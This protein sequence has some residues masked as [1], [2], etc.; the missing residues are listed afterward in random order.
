MSKDVVASYNILAPEYYDQ[1]RHP[2]CANLGEL[3][4][5]FIAK[6]LNII[7]SSQRVLEIGAGSSNVAMLLQANHHSISQL[8][9]TDI[10]EQM[11]SH[12]LMWKRHGASVYTADALALPHS[13]SSIDCVIA[14]LID[15]YNTPKLWTSLERILTVDG[16]IIVTTPSYE[17]AKRFRAVQGEA[18]GSKEMESAEFSL[19]D[20]SVIR[21]PSYI[22][23]L[24]ETVKLIESSTLS[25]LKFESLGLGNLTGI[26]IS[27]KSRVFK[28]KNSSLLWGFV[29]ARL[30]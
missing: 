3:S 20:G 7:T 25:V 15:P 11:L 18:R 24:A 12:S 17:W 22:Y 21:V 26:N 19:E 10:S 5:L 30:T 1:K 13:D 27:P 28:G 23:P 6:Y 29:I 9:I 14:S 16:Q 2:T 8:E 4:R